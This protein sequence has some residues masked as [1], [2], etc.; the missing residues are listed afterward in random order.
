[1]KSHLISLA[2]LYPGVIIYQST[3]WEILQTI[4]PSSG[5]RK[6]IPSRALGD[7]LLLSST[8]MTSLW[9]FSTK[10]WLFVYNSRQW[11]V[12][13]LGIIASPLLNALTC[14][15][16]NYLKRFFKQPHHILLFIWHQK[17]IWIHC[18]TCATLVFLHVFL[19]FLIRHQ[20]SPR[21]IL[22]PLSLTCTLSLMRKFQLNR[23]WMF[24]FEQGVEI[25][26]KLWSR[27]E[28]VLT[29]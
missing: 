26:P 7:H 19:V 29:L 4:C 23:A 8:I 24:E 28:M 20:I 16:G 1:M 10:I 22:S 11:A 18:S 5:C 17:T 21:F 2:F 3:A 13:H 25:S 12:C 14:C 6:Q 27:G 15:F 9:K